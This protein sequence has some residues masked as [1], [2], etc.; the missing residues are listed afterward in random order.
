MQI[1]RVNEIVIED[2][3]DDMKDYDLQRD[4]TALAHSQYLLDE[5]N[6]GRGDFSKDGTRVNRLALAENVM[7]GHS[8]TGTTVKKADEQIK[9]DSSSM[10]TIDGLTDSKRILGQEALADILLK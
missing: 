10:E 4:E 7:K 8:I 3:T 5:K 2:V 1:R 6:I 9:K